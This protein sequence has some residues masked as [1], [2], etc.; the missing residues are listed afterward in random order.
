[1]QLGGFL[2]R[3]MTH[4]IGF[5]FFL[6]P[7]TAIFVS[8]HRYIC[9]HHTALYA[10]YVSSY[11]YV[12]SGCGF[13]LLLML[14]MCLDAAIY[15]ISMRPCTAIYAIYLCSHMWGIDDKTA[16]VV[17]CY[18]STALLLFYYIHVWG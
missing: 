11:C 4:A 8:S 17:P 15:D 3:T 12:C 6:F 14:Y 1:M 16:S 2:E 5:F 18:S 13:I 7:P 10:I 9:C